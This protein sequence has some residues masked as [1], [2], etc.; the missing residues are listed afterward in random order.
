MQPWWRRFCR[1]Y[2][3]VGRKRSMR[4]F[5]ILPE[6]LSLRKPKVH[7]GLVRLQPCRW[8]TSCLGSRLDDGGTAALRKLDKPT[9]IMY[10]I[11]MPNNPLPPTGGRA[12]DRA[13]GSVASHAL[14][15]AHPSTP[16]KAAVRTKRGRRNNLLAS[17][18]L[19]AASAA[20]MIWPAKSAHANQP[21]HVQASVPTA[22]LVAGAAPTAP[23]H[24]RPG[25]PLSVRAQHCVGKA[26]AFYRVNADVLH[27][28]MLVE[29]DGRP[30]VVSRN[31][32][33]TLDIGM[34]QINSIHLRELSRYG[35]RAEHLLDECVAAFVAAWHYARQIARLGNT[36][37][38]IG[39]Y[40]SRTP[41]HNERYQRL[42][43]ERLV[44][45]GVLPNT[46]ARTAA[47]A[48]VRRNAP[49]VYSART[50]SV[51]TPP[52]YTTQNTAATAASN[53]F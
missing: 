35:I 24:F 10:P 48:P 36:W 42:V 46:G 9:R 13:P 29:S 18:V 6:I 34:A 49:S 39:A 37:Q 30:H 41:R 27:A 20:W 53:L 44:R 50:P 23:A 1:P 4:M 33:G 51:R 21:L 52:A 12:G 16:P 17:V 28:I 38:A 3:G 26:A 2:L 14:K 7:S 8:L 40:H 45:M 19:L 32:N 5:G 31:S 15:H 25:S 22:N 47:A 43:F 11:G